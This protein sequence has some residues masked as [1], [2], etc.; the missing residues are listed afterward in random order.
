MAD[1]KTNVDSIMNF[2]RAHMT[3]IPDNQN[4]VEEEG[5]EEL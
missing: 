1:V 4:E 2:A 3:E 5:E